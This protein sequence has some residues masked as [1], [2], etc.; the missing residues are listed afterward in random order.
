M[1]K[2]KSFVAEDVMGAGCLDNCKCKSKIE[3]DNQSW[4][5]ENILYVVGTIL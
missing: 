3:L 1:D 2:I 5:N 4:N